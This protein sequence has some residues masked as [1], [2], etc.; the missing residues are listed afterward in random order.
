MEAL[1][2]FAVCP[3]WKPLL[4][5]GQIRRANILTAFTVL[6]AKYC[7]PYIGMRNEKTQGDL[8]V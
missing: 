6:F 7:K 4:A 1:T 3:F 5:A 8:N 2:A